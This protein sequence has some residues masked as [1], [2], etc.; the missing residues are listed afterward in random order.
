MPSSPMPC[1]VHKTGRKSLGFKKDWTGWLDRFMVW[2]MGKDGQYH[3]KGLDDATFFGTTIPLPSGFEF[4]IVPSSGRKMLPSFNEEYICAGIRP[5]NKEEE[6]LGK[7]SPY[8]HKLSENKSIIFDKISDAIAINA[9]SDDEL[10]CG[11]YTPTGGWDYFVARKD[12]TEM[13]LSEWINQKTEVDV[14]DFHKIPE[15]DTPVMGFPFLSRNGK[16]MVSFRLDPNDSQKTNVSYIVLKDEIFTGIDSPNL[17]QSEQ[18]GYT[19]NKASRMIKAHFDDTQVS[20]FDISGSLLAH[21]SLNAGSEWQLPS[22]LPE[23]IYV[24]RIVQKGNHKTL[25]IVL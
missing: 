15:T 24:L 25:K 20:L 8:I 7:E 2:E 18:E 9:W 1:S 22:T 10:L 21:T 23:G 6:H 14:S 12:G 5:Y 4:A 16:V 13:T 19:Y 11:K 17:L 3:S